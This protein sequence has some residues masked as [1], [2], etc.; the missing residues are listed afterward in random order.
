MFWTGSIVDP[1]LIGSRVYCRYLY[2]HQNLIVH[3]RRSHSTDLQTSF[4]ALNLQSEWR[5]QIV[6]Q[7]S[8]PCPQLQIQLSSTATLQ[9]LKGQVSIVQLSLTLLVGIAAA[10]LAVSLMT[11]NIPECSLQYVSGSHSELVRRSGSI[12][13]IDRKSDTTQSDCF[14]CRCV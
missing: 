13:Q 9:G 7:F 12:W 2:R 8:S 4:S 11:S 10:K 6:N 5:I 1:C 3:P 14:T